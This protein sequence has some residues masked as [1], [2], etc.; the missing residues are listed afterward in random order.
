MSINK[1]KK[2]A[3]KLKG[4]NLIKIK[5]T[6]TEQK[7]EIEDFNDEILDYILND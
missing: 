4:N 2:V 7:I 3:I 6:S 1:K 5:T